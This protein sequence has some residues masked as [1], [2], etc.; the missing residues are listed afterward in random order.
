[1]IY[2]CNKCDEKTI[3]QVAEGYGKPFYSCINEDCGWYAKLL[4]MMDE[5]VFV[6]H[7]ELMD[8]FNKTMEEH[9]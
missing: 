4:I 2:P 9:E 8:A 5:G 7:D 3:I 6:P 1:M